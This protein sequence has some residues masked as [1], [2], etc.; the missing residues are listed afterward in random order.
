MV[1]FIKGYNSAFNQNVDNSFIQKILQTGIKD[2]L[3]SKQFNLDLYA[4]KPL[5]LFI[6][7]KPE[8]T[9]NMSNSKFIQSCQNLYTGQFRQS[10]LANVFDKNSKVCYFVYDEPF[11]D[12]QGNKV[13]FT[14]IA[15]RMIRSTDKGLYF[16]RVYPPL[17]GRL[18]SIV[19]ELIEKYTGMKDNPN[20]QYY[21]P[22]I[23]VSGLKYPYLDQPLKYKLGNLQNRDKYG[24]PEYFSENKR[25]LVLMAINNGDITW[26]INSEGGNRI[27]DNNGTF[28]YI[29]DRSEIRSMLYDRG[30]DDFYNWVDVD[31]LVRILNYYD[32]TAIKKVFNAVK[33]SYMLSLYL[34]EMNKDESIKLSDFLSGLK[35]MG[36]VV[37]DNTIKQ[38]ASEVADKLS[39]YLSGVDAEMNYLEKQKVLNFGL[40]DQK[41]SANQW[42]YSV[43]DEDVEP[44]TAEEYYKGFVEIYKNI[45]SL[46]KKYSSPDSD[47]EIYVRNSAFKRLKNDILVFKDLINSLK[48]DYSDKET[49][50]DEIE[51]R[52]S[53]YLYSYVELLLTSLMKRKNWFDDFLMLIKTPLGID[54][55]D[56]FYEDEN[57]LIA[58]LEVMEEVDRQ[59]LEDIRNKLDED[60]YIY[61]YTDNAFG[62]LDSYLG[63]NVVAEHDNLYLLSEI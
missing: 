59:Y 40:N 50:K 62:D 48:F 4:G 11:I 20:I 29:Y 43:M 23:T 35:K 38:K 8:D 57:A 32:L 39:D 56:E 26:P 46:F 45:D 21:E 30:Y 60:V 1:D 27:E 63:Y 37:D 41:S 53:G 14:T 17:A 42:L 49:L 2:I 10:L 58:F 55:P 13:P 12:Q 24:I 6:T 18:S 16:D 44:E 36:V 31:L 34:F 28:Y 33:S 7:S 25:N 15:R 54:S 52:N 47:N 9:L 19:T 3:D 22:D 51:N 5:F 61:E